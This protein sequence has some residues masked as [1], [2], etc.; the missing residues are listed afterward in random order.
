MEFVLADFKMN[1]KGFR[2]EMGGAELESFQAN[3]VMLYGHDR[4]QMPIGYW[5]EIRLE[6]GKLMAKPVFDMEDPK[7]K[8]VSRKVGKKVIR[9]ASPAVEIMEA[10]WQ[11]NLEGDDEFVVKRWGV[12]EASI[13]PI[14][15]QPGSLVR[16]YHRT[17]DGGL[18]ELAAANLETV[19]TKPKNTYMKKVIAFLGLDEKATEEQVLEAIQARQSE[20]TAQLQAP[21]AEALGLAKDVAATELQSTVANLAAANQALT[22]EKE[23]LTQKVNG[24]TTRVTEVLEANKAANEA[25]LAADKLANER[26][27]WDYAK[28][29]EEDPDGFEQL[30][31]ANPGKAREI[32][33]RETKGSFLPKF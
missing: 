2:L 22:S 23:A 31:A 16:L 24:L 18:V 20:A 9:A 27:R 19:F 3:P 8:E 7:A 28:W 25:K 21:L 11:T 15:A 32:I 14:P 1:R 29:M 4:S 30:E 17:E 10:E 26:K 13:V 33:N 12:Q 6:G 5:D